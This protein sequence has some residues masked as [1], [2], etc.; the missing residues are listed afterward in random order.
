VLKVFGPS[1]PQLTSCAA[2]PQVAQPRSP[3]EDGLA[4]LHEIATSPNPFAFL[5]GKSGKSRPSIILPAEDGDAPG[6]LEGGNM[7]LSSC[8]PARFVAFAQPTLSGRQLVYLPADLGPAGPAAPE[9]LGQ[10]QPSPFPGYS[11]AAAH[12]WGSHGSP[13]PEYMVD[14]LAT[15][16]ALYAGMGLG[17][18]HGDAIAAHRSAMHS[19]DGSAGA[20]VPQPPSPR[21]AQQQHL[22][23]Q[24][25]MR[26]G[27]QGTG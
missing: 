20:A 19:M 23:Q 6:N 11:K 1:R 8:Q 21:A 3:L 16:A 5:L 12:M 24:H 15:P 10:P 2:R 22:Q 25:G 14:P 26:S 18:D 17:T 27:R 9:A 13:P 7:P 4:A